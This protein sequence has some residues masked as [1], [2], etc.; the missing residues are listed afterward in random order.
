[1]DGGPTPFQTFAVHHWRQSDFEFFA[2][3]S[4]DLSTDLD[5]FRQCHRGDQGASTRAIFR[6]TR[7]IEDFRQ[8][9]GIFCGEMG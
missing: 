3:K 2:L 9:F 6:V 5:D 8:N 1:M 4:L 7:E